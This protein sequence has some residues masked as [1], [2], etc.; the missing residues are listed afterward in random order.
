MGWE[1]FQEEVHLSLQVTPWALLEKDQVNCL[2]A[3]ALLVKDQ[4]D[5]LALLGKN[6]ADPCLLV[7]LDQAGSLE[8]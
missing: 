6:Q 3:W 4:V 2:T 5:T 8:G 1:W 7:V